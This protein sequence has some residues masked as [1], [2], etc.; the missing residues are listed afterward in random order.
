MQEGGSPLGSPG[1]GATSTLGEVAL[2]LLDPA[3]AVAG[4]DTLCDVVVV[5]GEGETVAVVLAVD[6]DS[7]RAAGWR[8]NESRGWTWGY[9]R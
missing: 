4:T 1:T 5:V 9:S 8:W 7:C 6:S 3:G 2:M